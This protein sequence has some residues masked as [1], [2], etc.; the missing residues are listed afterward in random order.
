MCYKFVKCWVV[1]L[2][3]SQKLD[4]YTFF[5]WC[6]RI[7]VFNR[8]PDKTAISVPNFVMFE[9]VFHSES[10]KMPTTLLLGLLI[11][12]Y[13]QKFDP[14]TFLR[15]CV[16]IFVFDRLGTKIAVLSGNF[17]MFE[18]VFHS[19]S[20]KMPTTLVLGLVI[21]G[22]SQKFDPYTFLRWCVRIFVFDR[23]GTKIAVLSGN[24]VMFELVFHSECLKMPTTLLLGLVILGYS[25]NF[26]PYTFLR[27]CVRIFVFDR[28][29]EKTAILVPNFVMFELVFH[30][31]SLKMPTTLLLGLVILG[32]S[33]KLD[34]YT[35]LRWCVRI[36]VFDR[37]GTK[38]AVLSGNFVMFELVFHSES[39]KMPTTLVLGL[40][41]LGYSQKFDPYT[42]LRW[43]V[44][45]FVFDRLG[46]EIAVLSG[47]FVMFELVFHSESL[48]M[49]TTLVLGLVILGY[50]QKFDPYTF[51]R[52]CV[53]IFV[54]DRLPDKTAIL[55]PTFVMF[56]LVFHSESL[57][58]PT[59]LLLGLVIL[60]YSQKFDPYTF[61]RWC[62]RIFVFD[63][64]GTKIAVLSGNFVMFEL[65]FHSESLK[66][67]TTLLLGLVILG[68]SQKFDPY[69]FLRWCVRI[70]VFDRLGTKI[71]V[72][73]GNFV[74]FEL[75]FHSE[76][77]KMPTTLLLGLVIL[78]YSQKFDPYTFLR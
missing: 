77:L 55:V 52:W 67:P 68:Y 43:C 51:L 45:I 56:E 65:V 6:V 32:Y 31:E 73:S 30:S 46:T 41:I 34:P 14:Y 35:V 29:P 59:T 57:K 71:A 69:T 37:L 40:V 10:L 11:L 75:V 23:L 3:Y 61:L 24:F 53:R 13:S 19:E 60:G 9:L 15:W 1:I 48:K 27:W 64:L 76:S 70:F 25:Q 74:M 42:F 78:R 49:P 28:L 5:R 47:N 63:R 66:M 16:R 4:P 36:F 12:G 72:L 26:D 17:D 54:F 21:L 44:R 50:S 2:R 62:V 20:L 58:V 38:I 39:L 7:F 33:Q 8:L 22:Y 18:L